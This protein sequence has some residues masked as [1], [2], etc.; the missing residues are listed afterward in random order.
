MGRKLYVGNLTYGVG[1]GDLQQMFE[2]FGTVQSAQ[3]IMDRDTG[4]SK[5]FGFVEMGSDQEA[6][7]A[8]TG[9]NG[10][11]HGEAQDRGRWPGRRPSILSRA[12]IGVPARSVTG[13]DVS[14]PTHETARGAF[15]NP[16]GDCIDM[17]NRNL[18]RLLHVS[19]MSWVRKVGHPNDLL[20]KD[21]KVKCV[22]LS[23]DRERKRIALGLK[24]MA[25]DP[26]DGDIPARYY[27]GDVKQGKV[28]KLTNFGVFVELE[29]GLEGLMHNSEL[30]DE[31]VARPE[32]VLKVG[33]VIEVRVLRID[34]EERKIGLSRRQPS[35]AAETGGEATPEEGARV[36]QQSPRE[37]RGGTGSAAGKLFTMPGSTEG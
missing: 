19:D 26:W 28:T 6:Q 24:Q 18:L 32:D 12:I 9:L 31:K 15:Q 11:D 8:I 34:V 10:K 33:D 5:G 4:R 35:Q 16:R 37:L 7:A 36:P 29:P 14:F 23:V 3:V 30:A 1:D 17:V 20:N 21:D 27:A 25:S 13:G 2:T 22:V